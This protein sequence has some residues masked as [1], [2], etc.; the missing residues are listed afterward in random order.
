MGVLKRKK[1]ADNPQDK[2]DSQK[3]F[4]DR[5]SQRETFK[6][7]LGE[8]SPE[9]SVLIFYSGAGGV[10]KTALI[11][12]LKNYLS[13]KKLIYKYVYYAFPQ[14]TD[15]LSTLNA[16]KKTLIDQYAVTFPLFEKGCIQYYQKRGDMV[17]NQQIKETL[18]KSSILHQKFD[19]VI[20]KLDNANSVAGVVGNF[21]EDSFGLIDDLAD[22]TAI[23]KIAK[24]GIGELNKFIT[25]RAQKAKENSDE[26]YKAI[27]QELKE[28]SN[29]DSAEPLRE[30]LP[31]LFARDISDWTA[32]NPNAKLVIF[33]DTY[34]NLT[35]DE[36]DAKKH[37]KLVSVNRTVP[38]DWWLETLLFETC[39]AL[40]VIAGRSE[41]SKIGEEIEITKGEMLFPLTALEDNFAD[42][43]LIKAG[44]TDENLR[45]GIVKL[46][47]GYPNY[48]QVCIVYYKEILEKGRVPTISDFGEK[49]EDV[50]SR[51][52]DFMNDATRNMVKRLCILGTWTDA[53]AM[54]VLSILHEN[55]RDTY[56]R[57]KKLSFVTAQSENIFAFDKTIQKILF[58]HLKETEEEF[59][60]DTRNAATKFFHSAFYE[61]DAEENKNISAD[62][63][64]SFFKF[65][66]EI[67]LR[68][69]DG[70]EYLMK[71]FVENLAPLSERFDDEVIEGVI[72][73]FQAKIEDTDGTENIPFAYFEH[74]L[75]QIKLRQDK[76]KDA[77]ELAESAYNKFESLPLKNISAEIKISVID[78]LAYVY[79]RLERT[80]A[81]I[82]LCEKVVAE[83]EKF[84]RDKTDENII[85]AKYKLALAF[86]NGDKQNK[87]IDVYAEIY[88]TLEPFNDER[89]IYAAAN[90]ADVLRRAKKYN[91][92]LP[93]QE[94]I[95]AF[96][97]NTDNTSALLGAL[98]M[99]QPLLKRI[100]FIDN[101]ER[102][103]EL[104]RELIT[105]EE[106]VGGE[107]SFGVYRSL[108]DFCDT[109]KKLNRA[110]EAKCELES[111]ADK[112]KAQLNVV[113]SLDE[114]VEIM[115]F[116]RGIAELLGNKTEVK[117]W[118]ENLRQILR[119]DIAVKTR[120]PIEDFDAA[121]KAIE[122]LQN[123]LGRGLADYR[124]EVRLQRQIIE[125]LQKNPAA[126]E[127]EII[128]A[129]GYLADILACKKEGYVEARALR[130]E[131][132]EYFK[133]K[134]PDDETH[135]D[136]LRAMNNLAWLLQHDIE[137]Y[138]AALTV[139]KDIHRRLVKK[140]DDAKEI[141][142]VMDN[143]TSLHFQLNN[144]AE[145]LKW[146]KDI[147]DFCRENFVENAPEVIDAMEELSSV[148]ENMNEYD[149]AENLR[150]EIADIKGVKHGEGSNSDV[151]DAKK[152]IAYR[153]H[154]AGKYD[155][156][157]EILNEIVDLYRKNHA[158]NGGDRYYIIDALNNVASLL[159]DL[160][161]EDEVVEIRRKIVEE[162]KKDY[163]DIVKDS[164]E[165]SDDAIYE[166]E[167]IADAINQVGDYEE[168][169]TY[170]KKIVELRIAADAFSDDTVR[171]LESLADFYRENGDEV[172]EFETRL[173]I[174]EIRKK[175]LETLRAESD[176]EE[177][178]WALKCLATA[179]NDV[180]NFDEVAYWE[181][182]LI[183][184]RRRSVEKFEDE[185]GRTDSKTINALNNLADDL[186]NYHLYDEELTVHREIVD[187]LQEVYLDEVNEEIFSAKCELAWTFNREGKYLE[188]LIACQ[189]I[190]ELQPQIEYDV[191]SIIHFNAAMYEREK[192]IA[193]LKKNYSDDA[194]EVIDAEEKLENLRGKLN[195]EDVEDVEDVEE[196]FI[197][198]SEIESR[199][200]KLNSYREVFGNEHSRTLEL[201]E[202]LANDLE[203]I[204]R[205]DEAA[206]L[207]EENLK[208]YETIMNRRVERFGES[209]R[210]TLD[211]MRDYA[212]YLEKLQRY[213][214]A[215]K[216]YRRLC[217]AYK[218]K[219]ADD[220]TNYRIINALTDLAALLTKAEKF[221]AAISVQD[222]IVGLLKEKFV[223]YE[224]CH[225]V[226]D[227]L[228]N[229]AN[230]HVA[231]KDFDAAISVQ[232]E[233]VEL[234]KRRY[235]GYE[236]H[237][238]IKNAKSDVD[239][240]LE[241]K[242][243][244][245]ASLSEPQ[246]ENL[247]AEKVEVDKSSSVSLRRGQKFDLTK[248]NPQLSN[249]I[250]QF[251][252]DAANNF[253]IDH[254]AF[255][256]GANG[257][258]KVDED[259]IFYNNP[260]HETGGVEYVESSAQ[261]KVDLS[262]IPDDVAKIDFT[263]TIY[264]ADIK[265][266]NFSQV[267]GAYISIVDAQNN[268]ELLRFD[269]NENFSVETAIIAGE[270]YRHKG[271]WKFNAIG[272][273]FSGG[274]ESLCKNFGV[275]L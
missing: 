190:A 23:G 6:S 227:A 229:L 94:K 261:I 73:K 56:N 97:R 251:G 104:Q 231:K 21:V 25:R 59:I 218:N 130:E 193:L 268:A 15:M 38:V 271:A 213:N 13:T 163:D 175:M 201:R 63:R 96:Y 68:T 115:E 222:E 18:N 203:K 54:R 119:E 237:S 247:D 101:A 240:L 155:E 273:G 110:D 176:E 37:E 148:Y 136:I 152:D 2:T 236:N 89:T 46:T 167:N 164:S 219:F 177:I 120:E 225:Y 149:E 99:L 10:G 3:F 206:K 118:E 221:D 181:D 30:F 57:V 208:A 22:V 71:Q 146:R 14:V 199:Q 137:D 7:N 31:T 107:Y 187:R 49:R 52:L 192:I 50:I 93:L 84:Y 242:E 43:F 105:L 191:D 182:E 239:S 207:R 67:I 202:K 17:S 72:E 210:I 230:I 44:V 183:A 270:I 159:E 266:Q 40:W 121:I 145:Q 1:S 86:E 228:A 245:L 264:D 244:Y 88:H 53:Y 168:E 103:L 246:E 58:D 55:N 65:W 170:R 238:A 196:D 267:N 39:G 232:N 42:E 76:V 35:G 140:N 204:S 29:A 62:D 165:T 235:E 215:E 4:I 272:A 19:S 85:D 95:V 100:S 78:T 66:Y 153:L 171:A 186:N 128:S 111:F 108:K 275:S 252:W 27:I 134:Y 162:H 132:V 233:I 198:E 265:T 139:L 91:D 124:E 51:L 200:E 173:Q 129:Q 249:L 82:E 60:F 260:R 144:Y 24:L 172:K 70:A 195:G 92:A 126:D 12:D 184:N 64:K 150:R 223:G 123:N 197:D 142:E 156:E 131:I 166:L 259:F 250:V 61:V 179:E 253:E 269:L 241:M 5:E 79:G 160:G 45:G 8:I 106:K 113:E 205:A 117:F 226:I 234:L 77:L 214:D 133:A 211:G 90:Y 262:K 98:D 243:N 16:L 125:L 154:D 80:A 263:L 11:E 33:L 255:L 151:I 112:C 258:V 83:C 81:E 109:L 114:K 75:A 143:I 224:F 180:G 185:F 257:K 220:K 216:I 41:I 135:E 256:L 116:L 158:E 254:S 209:H 28:R 169:L 194:E 174:V 74:L 127:D 141:L 32:E 102:I 178:N 274:L 122:N 188:Y 48:L 138:N 47:G 20:G 248:N 36:K 217:T 157:L 34:E 87:A 189:E 147:L 26:S 161:R 212:A 9:G 69:T